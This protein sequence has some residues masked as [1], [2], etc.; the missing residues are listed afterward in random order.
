MLETILSSNLFR[1]T[2]TFASGGVLFLMI[3]RYPPA[4]DLAGYLFSI[5]IFFSF[6]FDLGEVH[7]YSIFYKRAFFY[8]GDGITT[9]LVLFFPTRWCY[10]KKYSP[11]SLESQYFCLVE[12]YQL[13]Y[14]F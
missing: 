12:K 8:Y 3:K 7:Q 2:A 9:I 6:L 10:E 14:F 5:G 1:L 4:F 13:Y 11:S